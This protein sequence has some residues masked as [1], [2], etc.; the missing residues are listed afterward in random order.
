[1]LCVKDDWFSA[2]NTIC[3]VLMLFNPTRLLGPVMRRYTEF[4]TQ[5]RVNRIR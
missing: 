3:S 5:P 4:Q 2:A 1:M